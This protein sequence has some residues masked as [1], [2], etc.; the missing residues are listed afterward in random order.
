MHSVS[1]GRTYP[2][3]CITDDVKSIV[4]SGDKTMREI[5][6][7]RTQNHVAVMIY[8]NNRFTGTSYHIISYCIISYHIVSY[9]IVSYHIVSYH[10]VSYHIVLYHIVSYHIVSYHIISYPVTQELNLGIVPVRFYADNNERSYTLH[11]SFDSLPISSFPATDSYTTW[12]D[13]IHRGDV[14]LETKFIMPLLQT[15]L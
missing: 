13:S 1:I 8:Q 10:I 4:T 2:I 15:W 14:R 12:A 11:Q 7:M 6:G 3:G 5:E 9:H